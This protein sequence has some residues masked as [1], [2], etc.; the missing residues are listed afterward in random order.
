MAPYTTANILEN[1][2]ECK[3]LWSSTCRQPGM[4]R[5][6]ELVVGSTF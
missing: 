4:N 3:L 2:K 1:V 6:V 5:N